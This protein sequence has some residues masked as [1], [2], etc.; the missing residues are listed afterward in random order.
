[1]RAGKHVLCEKPLG[2]TLEEIDRIAAAARECGR[3]VAEAFMYRHHPQTQR[4]RELVK[5]GIVG[6]LRAVKGAF[7]FVF[8]RSGD[9]RWDPALGGG[10]LW[11]VG[12]YPVSYARHVLGAEPETACAWQE[13]SPTGVDE[14]FFGQLRFPSG[15]T[16]QFDSGFRAPLRTEMQ[17]VGSEGVLT[18]PR[19]FKPGERE[20]VLLVRGDRCERLAMPGQTLYL[21]EVE[22][23]E[24]ALL[25]GRAPRVSLEDSRGNCAAL[26]ALRRAAVEGRAVPVG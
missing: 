26:L 5:G 18:I 14:A 16:L 6:E 22:D 8:E 25:L 24:D 10:S 23:M 21:G 4:V 19:P 11:D 20:E 12:C 2:L 15:A 9:V 1:V 17:F 3:V 13:L 7:S